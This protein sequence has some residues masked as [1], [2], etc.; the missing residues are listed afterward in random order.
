M[1]LHYPHLRLSNAAGPI[2][3]SD[4]YKSLVDQLCLMADASYST[5]PFGAVLNFIQWKGKEKY[6]MIKVEGPFMILFS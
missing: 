5:F 4:L 3:L 2:L 6:L 1:V